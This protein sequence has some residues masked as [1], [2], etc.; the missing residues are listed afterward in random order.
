MK[1]ES[2]KSSK[3][4]SSSEPADDANLSAN[5]VNNDI[6]VDPRAHEDMKRIQKWITAADLKQM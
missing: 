3:A 1:Q 5:H 4:S 6:K 2:A